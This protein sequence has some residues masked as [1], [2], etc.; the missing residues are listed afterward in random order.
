MKNREALGWLIAAAELMGMRRLALT[1]GLILLYSGAAYGQAEQSGPQ[2]VSD[3]EIRN[4]L[5]QRS[6]A[7]YAGACPC[8]E[9][10]N[11]RGARCGGNSA[12]SRPGGSRPLCYPTDVTD[13]MVQRHRETLAKQ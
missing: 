13:A 1:L 4:L 5:V 7:A 3:A 12:Y 9:S 11:S 10:R 6:I 2:N 8:P